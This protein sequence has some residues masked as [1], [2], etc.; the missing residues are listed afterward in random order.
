MRDEK[1]KRKIVKIR[2]SFE[3]YEYLL[4][5]TTPRK[6]SDYI[7][8]LLE[9]DRQSQG[10]RRGRPKGSRNIY[11][12]QKKTPFLQEEA[13]ARPLPPEKPRERGFYEKSGKE[14]APDRE[15]ALFGRTERETEDSV[16]EDTPVMPEQA[17]MLSDVLSPPE[18]IPEKGNTEENEEA[19]K[20]L[21]QDMQEFY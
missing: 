18:E 14:I 2:L 16:P 3:D 10:S 20:R 8:A 5:R 15:T 12:P 13:N 1:E 7:A 11:P 21:L 6:I 4:S 17:V 19:A 9:Q